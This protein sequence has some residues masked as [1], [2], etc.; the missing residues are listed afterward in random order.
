MATG[1]YKDIA[2]NPRANYAMYKFWQEKARARMTDP[3]KMD[4]AAP[5]E[6]FQWIGGKRNALEQK[7]FEMIDKPNVK[8][9]N[10][11][12]TP[13]KEIVASGVVVVAEG[14]AEALHEL[15]VLIFSTGYDSVTSGLYDM[16]ITDRNG[17]T[18]EENWKDG[19]QTYDGMKVPDMPNAFL[20]YG[21]QAPTALAN[22]PTFI[23]LQV[24]WT[25]QHLDGLDQRG[26][27]IVETTR[28]AA[29]EWADRAFSIWNSP[30]LRDQ[31]SWWVGANIPGKKREPLIWLGGTKLWWEI[32]TA[33]LADWA[34][35]V[36]KP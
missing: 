34:P 35:F 19:I 25:G 31:D 17:E 33:G 24:E 16:N 6:Q 10:L 5:L 12:I 11:K 15:D 2:T 26:D 21:P 7:Y 20:L 27:R 9:I 22:G 14:G 18:L 8:L 30:K 4:I 13:I 32:C 3:S 1:G 23:E 29:K 36:S 28:E